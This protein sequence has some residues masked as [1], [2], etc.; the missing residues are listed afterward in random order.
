VGIRFFNRHQKT[1]LKTGKTSPLKIRWWIMGS[2]TPG[3]IHRNG[4]IPGKG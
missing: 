4:V 3:Q 2:H 1:T